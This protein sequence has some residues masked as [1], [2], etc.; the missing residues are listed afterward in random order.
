MTAVVQKQQAAMVRAGNV[1]VGAVN[2]D[3]VTVKSTGRTLSLPG[4]LYGDTNFYIKH[5]QMYFPDVRFRS[6]I[7]FPYC[8]VAYLIIFLGSIATFVNFIFALVMLGVNGLFLLMYIQHLY[9]IATTMRYVL[10]QPKV[11]NNMLNYRNEHL[12]IS[13]EVYRAQYAA[14]EQAGIG[15]FVKGSGT[16][17]LQVFQ[18][19]AMALMKNAVVISCFCFAGSLLMVFY[20]LATGIY[21]MVRSFS[22][23]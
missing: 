23:N 4:T 13:L 5:S 7:Y 6:F 19:S 15:V 12:E 22:Y 16:V 8:Q 3:K 17:K 2:V 18:N 21:G 1:E 14:C 11:P 9:V 10:R 20:C